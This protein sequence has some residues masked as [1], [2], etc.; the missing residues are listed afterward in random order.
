MKR[1]DLKQKVLK[2]SEG[3]FSTLIDLMLGEIFFGIEY[4]LGYERYRLTRSIE[5]AIARS[6]EDLEK[7]N[8]K[9]IKTALNTLKQRGL[10]DYITE[11]GL[12]KPILTK[13]GKQ[14]LEA[15]I[16]TYI[17]SRPWNR[18]L[19]LIFYDFPKTKKSLRDTFRDHLYQIGAGRMQK[20]V[21]LIWY[22]PT[23]VLREFVEKH[24]LKGLIVISCLGKDGYV[25]GEKVEDLVSRVY[26]LEKLNKRYQ[27]FLAKYSE[28]GQSLPRSRVA[29][30]F[31]SILK[32]DPQLPSELLPEDWK[33][34]D[35]YHLYKKLTQPENH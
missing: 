23:E 30:E 22:D 24:N 1:K 35:A 18:K 26:K 21:Y 31:L 15:V 29:F 28:P 34:D 25:S 3:I 5:K 8:Y 12:I 4:F 7:I 27:E 9:S 2:I 6:Y 10:I 19:Y 14:R 13:Q 17:K 33:G 16:P 11:E 20:S 32:D